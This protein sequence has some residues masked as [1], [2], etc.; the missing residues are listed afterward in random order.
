MTQCHIPGDL[1]PQA[2]IFQAFWDLGSF[3]QQNTYFSGCNQ[4][5]DQ[6]VF[7]KKT[8]ITLQAECPS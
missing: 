3:H 8:R 4:T 1:N 6:N 5:K 2:H 7:P